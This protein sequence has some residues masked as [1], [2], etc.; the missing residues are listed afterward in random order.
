MCLFNGKKSSPLEY[1]NAWSLNKTMVS[2]SLSQYMM[3]Q[4]KVIVI[5]GFYFLWNAYFSGIY[6]TR[7]QRNKIC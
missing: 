7:L 5:N 3:S 6:R 2:Q 4:I 1:M